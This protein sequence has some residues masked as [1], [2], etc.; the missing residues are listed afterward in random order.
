MGQ[1][2]L[3]SFIEVCLNVAIGFVVS[4]IANEFIMSSLDVHLSL[5]QHLYAVMAFTV[6]S[7]VRGYII[8]R[9]FNAKLNKVARRLAHDE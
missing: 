6:L 4:L 1:S 7:V 2:K 5:G 9:Y 3:S 8:R